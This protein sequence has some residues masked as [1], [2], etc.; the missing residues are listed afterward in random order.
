M[1]IY[2]ETNKMHNFLR[3]GGRLRSGRFMKGPLSRRFGNKSS[4]E[5]LK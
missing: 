2:I 1:E 3:V 5:E 4:E